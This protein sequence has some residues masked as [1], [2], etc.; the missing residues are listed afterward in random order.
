MAGPEASKE[1]Q[2]KEYERMARQGASNRTF[3][4][5]SVIV[6]A[7]LIAGGIGLNLAIAMFGGGILI[8]CGIMILGLT[9]YAEHESTVLHKGLGLEA[10]KFCEHCGKT[11]AGNWTYCEN[12]GSRI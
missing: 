7:I 2:A 5:F 6:G 10:A 3:A 4:R 12:C 1:S 8:I 9:G 11:V